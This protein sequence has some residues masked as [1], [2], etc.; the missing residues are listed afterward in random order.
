MG[1]RSTIETH[2]R[3]SEIEEAL[4]KNVP[5]SSVSEQFGVS[6]PALYRWLNK[7]AGKPQNSSASGPPVH[8]VSPPENAPARTSG[9]VSPSDVSKNTPPLR[10][11]QPQR[12]SL[13]DDDLFDICS[14][15]F[16]LPP[17]QIYVP[18]DRGH[19]ERVRAIQRQ[20]GVDAAKAEILRLTGQ[21]RK[22]SMPPHAFAKMMNVPPAVVAGW[23]AARQA[24]D[25][26][27]L[28]GTSANDRTAREYADLEDQIQRIDERLAA[29]NLGDRVFTNLTRERARLVEARGKLL[30]RAGLDQVTIDNRDAGSQILHE[31]MFRSLLSGLEKDYATAFPLADDAALQAK[32]VAEH[33]ANYDMRAKTENLPP[34]DPNDPAKFN[35][36]EQ[37]FRRKEAY[38]LAGLEYTAELIPSFE[39]IGKTEIEAAAEQLRALNAKVVNE[40]EPEV[41]PE[42][43]AAEP[44]QTP[45]PLPAPAPPVRERARPR[46][47]PFA[48]LSLG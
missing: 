34:F 2:P 33:R 10:A 27:Q 9:N 12:F 42:P 44:E 11:V 13:G 39:W 15:S 43:V 16:P 22:L 45:E 30:A 4:R 40:P 36:S 31:D 24:Q 47:E 23:L 46:I 17:G 25:I 38:R 28:F 19:A 29:P 20:I 41:A 8:P 1:R 14:M 3:F 5:V 48:G 26:E 35:Y 18:D 32:R 6:L 37:S 21:F 7:P